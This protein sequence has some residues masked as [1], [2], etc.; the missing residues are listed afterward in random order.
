MKISNKVLYHITNY[1]YHLGCLAGLSWQTVEISINYFKYLTVS[2]INIRM[3]GREEQKSLNICFEG[4]DMCK[5]DTFQEILNAYSSSTHGKRT[6]YSI[7]SKR[8][9]EAEERAEDREFYGLPIPEPLDWNISNSFDMRMLYDDLLTIADKFKVSYKFHEIFDHS[10]ALFNHSDLIGTNFI[11]DYYTCYNINR[12]STAAPFIQIDWDSGFGVRDIDHYQFNQILSR[13]SNMIEDVGNIYAF[14]ST[15]GIIPWKEFYFNPIIFAKAS[16]QLY[17]DLTSY[18][19]YIEKLQLPYIDA[20]INYSMLNYMDRSDAVNDCINNLG[21]KH[22]NE[23]YRRK[24]FLISTNYTT[25]DLRQYR[26]KCEIKY[27]NSD[28]K[29]ANIYT[30]NVVTEQNIDDR[31]NE[32][33]IASELSKDPSIEITS[34]PKIANIDYVTYVL[35]ACGTWFGFC[36]LMINPA[37]LISKYCGKNETNIPNEN[38]P[39]DEFNS[40]VKLHRQGM[41]LKSHDRDIKRLKKS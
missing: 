22:H 27:S 37:D 32:I 31:E 1:F 10:E 14:M 2:S 29:S 41:A 13:N 33:Q 12:D 30:T 20:C 40:N 16:K 26:E 4:I 15:P 6:L 9:T 3:P 34:Q 11:L 21:I 8:K 36:F 28:C 35:G 39:S 7:H 25:T 5:L 23:G 38:L 17:I 18:G 24:I 19:H